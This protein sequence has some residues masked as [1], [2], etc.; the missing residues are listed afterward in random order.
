MSKPKFK[1]LRVGDK[2]T[3]LPKD[4]IGIIKSINT[5]NQTAHVVYNCGGDWKHSQKYTGAMTNLSALKLGW[6]K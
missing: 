3:Y 4:E 5:K 2:V 1:I 6:D